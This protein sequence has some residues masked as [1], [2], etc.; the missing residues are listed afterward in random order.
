MDVQLF[1]VN[2]QNVLYNGDNIIK[3]RMYHGRCTE[4][5]MF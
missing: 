2:K 5:E 3:G 4:A 1:V